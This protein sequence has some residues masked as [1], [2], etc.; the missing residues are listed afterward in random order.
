MTRLQTAFAQITPHPQQ[1]VT[2]PALT[3]LPLVDAEYVLYRLEEAGRT[4]LALPNVGPTTR[5]RT[6]RH[7]I[8]QSAIEAYGWQNVDQRVRPAI[9]SHAHV[10]R[11]DEAL[12]WIPLIPRDRYVLRRIVGA[13]ALV[14][15]VTERHLFS[16]RRLATLLGADH[17]AIQRWHAQGVDLIVTTLNAT[18]NAPRSAKSTP[19]A[20]AH[21]M[22][23]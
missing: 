16:W 14:S 15:P 2:A 22:Q 21:R 20:A 3:A 1:H 5:L 4:L 23:S 8:V 11:M 9:P 12:D 19:P 18:Q 10:T 6:S 7:D 13:R 17:K